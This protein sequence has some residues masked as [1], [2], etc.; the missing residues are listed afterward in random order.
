[1]SIPTTAFFIDG[2]CEDP[3]YLNTQGHPRGIESK[4]FVENFGS[5]FIIWRILISERMHE[6]FLQ[7]FWEMYSRS[8]CLSVA[9]T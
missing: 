7:R 1:M 5:V 4:R 3:A 9:S 2:P 8:P 6:I